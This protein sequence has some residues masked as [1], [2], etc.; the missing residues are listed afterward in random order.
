MTCYEKPPLTTSQQV[1]LLIKR[2]LHIADRAQAHHYLQHISYYRLRAYWL[3][4]EQATTRDD[5]HAFSAGADFTTVLTIYDFDRELRLLLIDA[6]ER[7]E[8]S[9]RARLSNALSLRYGAFA[10][11]EPTHFSKPQLWQQSRDELIKEYSRS[12]ETFAEHYRRQ[13]PQL[14]SPPLWV[15]CEMMTLGHL[16]RWLQNLRIPKDRQDIAETY[17]LD[18]KVLVSFAH[19]LSVV[20]NHCAHHGR[21]WNRKLSLKMQIPGK[22]PVGLAAMFNPAQDRK[23]YNTLTMLAY[24]LTRIS[25]A[26]TWRKRLQALIRATPQIDV[27]EM[28]FP[29]GWAQRAIW[30]EQTL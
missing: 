21:M 25:P 1:D 9:L 7:V 6:I 22:K 8:I 24:L 5:D 13:Y 2:G 18:E 19:H 20:R 15:A 3:P 30:L 27:T 26:S 17:G 12:H 28:G 16:S 14:T 29:Q 23:L 4:F 10:H 11:E